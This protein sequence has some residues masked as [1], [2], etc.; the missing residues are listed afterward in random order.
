MEY[1]TLGRSGLVVS[2]LCLGT[3]TFGREADEDA[4]RAM[5][6]RFTELGGTFVDTADVYT[7]GISEQI[8]G[9]AIADRRDDIVLTCRPRNGASRSPSWS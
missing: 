5:V 2:R 9:R 6:D 3:M 4:S 7:H 1:V 8:T